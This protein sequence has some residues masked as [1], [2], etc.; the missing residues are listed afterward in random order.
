MTPTHWLWLLFNVFVLGMLALDLGVFHRRAH[1][2][3]HKEAAVW[4]AVWIGLALVFNLGVWHFQGGQRALEFFTGYLIEKSLSLDNLFVFLVIFTYF[5]VEARYQHRVLYWGILGALVMRGVMIA[6]GAVL[7]ASFHWV[8]YVFGGFL[9]ITGIRFARQH[10]VSVEP[11]ANPLLRLLRRLLAVTPGFHEQHFFVRER[12]RLYATPLLVVLVL[13][14][15]SDLVF[16]VD[17]I[18]AIFAITRDTFIVYS[19]N[20]FAILGLRALFFLLVAV[21]PRF[22]YLNVGLGIILSFVGVKMLL[23]EHFE[24]PVLLSLG[25]VAAVLSVT[26]AASL[27]RGDQEGTTTP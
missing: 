8:V 19:S 16:A 26:I 20:V 21:L 13:I 3:S 23:S 15:S 5:R 22:R 17:S 14:E 11:E 27:W 18:P 25:V 1:A 7:L 12:G 24:I 2:V 10:G 9:I 4:S 6:V